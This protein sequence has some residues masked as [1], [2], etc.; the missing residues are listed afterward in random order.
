MGNPL[1]ITV[2]NV[3]VSEKARSATSK[4]VAT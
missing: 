3:Q 2:N 1:D 4:D